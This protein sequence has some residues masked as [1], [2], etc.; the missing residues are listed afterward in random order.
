MCLQG[1]TSTV[2][3]SCLDVCADVH[4]LVLDLAL[5]LQDTHSCWH[6]FDVAAMWEDLNRLA[7]TIAAEREAKRAAAEAAGRPLSPD[8]H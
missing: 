6:S 3:L 5:A 8:E 4:H 1:A 7:A 2:M